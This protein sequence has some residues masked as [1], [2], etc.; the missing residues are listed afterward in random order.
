MNQSKSRW[1]THINYQIAP[2][3]AKVFGEISE[4]QMALFEIIETNGNLQKQWKRRGIWEN[5]NNIVFQ[6]VSLYICVCMC[7]YLCLGV[8]VYV[9]KDLYSYTSIIYIEPNN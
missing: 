9:A 1:I 3:I 7:V 8:S 4:N 2:I 5:K 6:N